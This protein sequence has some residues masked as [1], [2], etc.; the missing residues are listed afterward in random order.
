MKRKMPKDR[1]WF[2]NEVHG[3]CPYCG[4]PIAK[5]SFHIDHIRPIALGGSNGK[6]NLTAVCPQCNYNKK[7]KPLR[8][9]LGI[10]GYEITKD[11]PIWYKRKGR[12]ALVNIEWKKIYQSIVYMIHAN[13]YTYPEAGKLLRL[14]VRTLQSQV[15][16]GELRCV[17]IGRR[18]YFT[19]IQLLDW[20]ESCRRGEC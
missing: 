7:D 18:V 8:Y 12:R 5:D 4:K 16:S 11:S 17:R 3:V 9:W 6:H 2:Y 14:T 1:D 19:D 13:L 10:N 15:K 20:V